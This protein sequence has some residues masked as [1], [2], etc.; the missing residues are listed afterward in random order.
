MYSP[1]EGSLDFIIELKFIIEENNR[2]RYD[3]E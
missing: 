2:S 1:L 3:F